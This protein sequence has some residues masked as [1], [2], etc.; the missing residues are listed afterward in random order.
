MLP[1]SGNLTLKGITVGVPREFH[2]DG[3]HDSALR[4][5][6]ETV[7]ILKDLGANVVSVSVPSVPHALPAYYVIACAEASSNLA[8]YDGLRYGARYEPESEIEK[9]SM[10]LHDV[11]TASR[12]H[13]LGAEVQRRI[14][15]GT[16]VLSAP[17][18]ESYY[19]KALEVRQQ[20]RREFAGAFRAHAGVDV[21]LTPTAPAPPFALAAPPPAAA[22]MYTNDVMTVPVNLAGLPALS[23]PVSTTLID[24]AGTSVEVPVGMQLIAPPLNEGNLMKVAH[25]LESAVD[26]QRPEHVYVLESR[27]NLSSR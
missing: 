11:I 1:S 17:S 21:L 12:T 26:F 13:G 19:E 3:L 10:Y 25:T 22:E 9:N 23:L 15:C 6:G 7:G 27:G 16:F 2:V 5:W 18:Y 24:I 8:R 14:L 20:L 4:A